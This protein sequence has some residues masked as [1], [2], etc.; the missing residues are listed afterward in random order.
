MKNFRDVMTASFRSA[1]I[2]SNSLKEYGGSM[3][4]G[5][6]KIAGEAFE[7]GYYK[8]VK[9]GSVTSV[10]VLVLGGG[11]V[12]G[13]VEVKRYYK[14]TKRKEVIKNEQNVGKVH[15]ISSRA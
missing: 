14:K 10:T 9:E 3:G 12:W 1:R 8:G 4:K 11:I 15:C 2:I 7:G 5:V 13:I 6:R